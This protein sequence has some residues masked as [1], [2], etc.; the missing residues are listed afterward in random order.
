[1]TKM[2]GHAEVVEQKVFNIRQR[3]GDGHIVEYAVAA[4]DLQQALA[5]LKVHHA[6]EDASIEGVSQM[7]EFDAVLVRR[8]VKVAQAPIPVVGECYAPTA[9]IKLPD[10]A[11]SPITSRRWFPSQESGGWV[12]RDSNTSYVVA[13][14]D[15]GA[16]DE[17]TRSQAYLVAM[18][19]RLAEV[20]LKA[21]RF[22][23]HKEAQ[24]RH[25][26]RTLAREIFQV[27]ADAGIVS[28]ED[29][30][31]LDMPAAH[32]TP[33]PEPPEPQPVVAGSGTWQPGD[34]Y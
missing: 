23:S 9:D 22:L 29:M 12:V 30:K 20:A 34:P 10:A 8:W 24:T 7:M 5:D 1:M 2:I 26:A 27:L 11:P 15:V 6:Y 4:N 18:A 32:S 31:E 16:T 3:T 25:Q 13:D 14:M 28:Q 21:V 19:P 17:V 33:R